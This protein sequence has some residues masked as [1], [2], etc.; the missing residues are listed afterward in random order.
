LD[1]IIHIILPVH[2]RIE[3]TEAF[4]ECLKKQTYKHFKLLLIDD[5][6][7]DGTSEM[8]KGHLPNSTIIAG[9]GKWWWAGSLHQGYKYLKGIKE[10]D[11]NDIVLIINDDT[12]I[13]A[14]FLEIGVGLIEKSENTLY[15]ANPYSTE[16]IWRNYLTYNI[17]KYRFDIDKNNTKI[18]CMHTRGLFIRYN[19]FLDIGG[20]Y[21]KL[22]PHYLSDYEYTYRAFKKGFKLAVDKSLKIEVDEKLTGVKWNQEIT[23]L[24]IKEFLS[25]HFSKKYSYNP[26][27]TLNFGYLTLPFFSFF[28]YAYIT[29]RRFLFD[30]LFV[31]KNNFNKLNNAS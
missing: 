28:P 18:I 17:K 14:N 27:Y 31:I 5:G 23:S 6:S 3:T 22:L 26:I 7:T 24:S 8:V 2:N 15:L 10:I 11:K 12:S 30:F 4:I 21:P 25:M 19:N 1:T 9:K 29:L 13:D 16:E 20:F